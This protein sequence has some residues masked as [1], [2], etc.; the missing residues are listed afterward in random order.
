MSDEL[1]DL[2]AALERRDAARPTPPRR[3]R[4]CARRRKISPPA[5]ESVKAMRPNPEAARRSGGSP[6]DWMP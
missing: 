6:R 4:I 1:D 3:R 5:Q 2:K